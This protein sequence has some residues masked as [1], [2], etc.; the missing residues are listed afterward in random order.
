[1][2]SDSPTVFLVDDDAP[3][4]RSLGLMLDL[5]GYR[6]REYG[7]PTDFLRDYSAGQPGCLVLDLRM[8]D[9]TGLELQQALRA[10]GCTIPIIFLSAFGDIPTSVQAIKAGAVDFLEK[11]IGTD[12]LLARIDEA[13]TEDRLAREDAAEALEIRGRAAQLTPRENE[14]I[15]L[16]TKGLTNKEIA[17]HL[18]ISPRTVE[19]HRARVME[20][21]QAENIADLCQM[22]A[23]CALSESA[24][25][26]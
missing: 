4:L 6:V 24:P 1:M 20:K 25:P 9:M 15:V 13:L 26:V 14:V 7:S 23:V 5:A 11:P 18:G 12:E 17:R 10:K 16:A 21:M 8:P 2:M 19:N 22:A 3:T